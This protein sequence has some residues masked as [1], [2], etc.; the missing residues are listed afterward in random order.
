MTGETQTYLLQFVI[1]AVI[2]Q[3]LLLV[4]SAQSG[5]ADG[6]I[7]LQG[8]AGDWQAVTDYLTPAHLLLFGIFDAAGGIGFSALLNRTAGGLLSPLE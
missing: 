5:T 2:T 1:G 8:I 7:A 3:I 4:F 6:M